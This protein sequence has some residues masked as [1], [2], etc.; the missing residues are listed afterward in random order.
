MSK[1][2]PKENSYDFE[3]RLYGIQYLILVIFIALGIRFYVLQVVRHDDFQARAE[4]N[5]IREIPILAP[6]GAILDRGENVLVDNTPASNIVL[7]PDPEFMQNLDQTVN[8][9]VENLG[10]DRDQ[11]VKELNNPLR[12]K[13]Q[14]ILVKQNATLADR[15]W[16]SAREFEYPE[17][18]VEEQPQRNYRYGKLAAH[19][20]GYIGE[21]S[22]K[23]LESPRYSGYKSGDIIG[24]GGIEA[25]YDKELRGKDG[26]RRV[27]VD[28]RGRP[29]RTLE[30]IPPTRGQDIIT[31][32]DIDMQRTAEE[33]FDKAGDTGVA[34]A[35]N[36][37]NGEIYALASRPAFDPN[38]FAQNVISGGEN[39]KEVRA[40]ITDPKHPL[41]NKSIQGIYPTGST[42]KLLMSTAALEEGII[43]PKE[44]RIVCGGGI[45]MGNRFVRCMGNHGA[46]PI[47]PAIVHSCDGYFYRLGLKMGVDMIHEWVTRFGMGQKTGIDLPDEQRGIIPSRERKKKVNPR[48]PEWKDFDTV[49]ASVGQGEVAVPPMQLL[50]AISGIVMGGEYYT[51][52]VLKVAK[53]TPIREVKYYDT[54]PTQLKLSPETVKILSYACWGV[55][56]EGGTAGGVGF[57]RDLNVGGKTGTAQVIAMEKAG[58]GKEHR[59][60]AWFI[61]FAPL[62]T[63]QKPELGVVVLT[64]HGGFGGRAS[65]PKVKMIMGVYFSKK[66]GRP[67]LPEL[68]AK[69][70]QPQPS[71]QPGAATNPPA[72]IARPVS[73]VAR[74]PN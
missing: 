36:P 25:V 42:W 17:I 28:S 31:T 47:H 55:V 30:I 19:V 74:K 2:N 62:H 26:M 4:N 68:V 50:R 61:G 46:P 73:D 22:P 57:P 65:A 38:I 3:L 48:N 11:L 21:I 45:S 29:I 39:R 9:M 71:P 66:F 53:E 49:L 43:T 14:P 59:D 24:L 5:R 23:Q 52:H 67:V 69:A 51:P 32:I 34:I 64:E 15:A 12:P 18:T 10:I 6:R 40:I 70:G 37:Q 27:I 7:T 8:A 58:R 16:V 35:M 20:L 41:Y 44:S 72:R 56:N 63:D 54:P 60:H 1:K 33:E 13:S